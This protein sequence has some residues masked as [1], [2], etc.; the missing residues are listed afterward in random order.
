MQHWDNH[1]HSGRAD[2]EEREDSA[3]LDGNITTGDNQKGKVSDS[4]SEIFKETDDYIWFMYECIWSTAYSNSKDSI[5]NQ[6]RNLSAREGDITLK[7]VNT[8][9]DGYDISE[10]Y[11]DEICGDFNSRC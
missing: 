10:D 11:Q 4:F 1:C 8:L 5:H 7:N 9:I 2:Q 6:K 3:R